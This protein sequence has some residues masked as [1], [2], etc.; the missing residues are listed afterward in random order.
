MEK[1]I[2]KVNS[3][4]IEIP[5]YYKQVDPMP[6]DPEN[7]VPYMVQ[8]ERALCIA[9]VGELDY[10][11]ALPGKKDELINGIRQC[12]SDNQGLIEVEAEKDYVYSIVKNLQEPSGIQYILTYQKFCDGFILN[13]QAFFEEIGITG[14][15]DSVVYEMCRRD[16][17]VGN[18]NDPFAG[19]VYDPYDNTITSGKRMNLS[20]QRK[21]DEMFPGY[22][23]SMCRELLSCLTAGRDAE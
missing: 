12:L 8:T 19:W 21:Y 22:P 14:Q 20:E 9:F 2:I 18:D 7:S 1:K 6:G 3:E 4:Q 11:K 17:L 13:V 10:S 15:R 16:K 23:L 5:D